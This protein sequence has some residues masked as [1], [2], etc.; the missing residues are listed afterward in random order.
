VLAERHDGLIWL[1][2][3]PWY[4]PKDEYYIPF[5]EPAYQAK[6]GPK[7]LVQNNFAKRHSLAILSLWQTWR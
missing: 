6:I 3:R 1:K 4:K 5:G 7:A 2:V